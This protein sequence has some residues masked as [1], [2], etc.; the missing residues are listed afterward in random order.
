M[1]REMDLSAERTLLCVTKVDQHTDPGLL[2]KV[3]SAI[4]AFSLPE[5]HVFCLRNRSQPENDKGL[6]LAEMRQ[7]ETSFFDNHVEL[8]DLPVHSKG[9]KALSA[10]LVELQCERLRATLPSAAVR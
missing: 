3:N 1:S 6:G 8:K 7:I 5:E 4:D 10:R 9:T 2:K